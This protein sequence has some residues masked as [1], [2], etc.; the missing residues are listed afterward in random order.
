SNGVLITGRC[1]PW[2]KINQALIVAIAADRKARNVLPADVVMQIGSIGLQSGNLGADRYDLSQTTDLE[3]GVDTRHGVDADTDAAGSKD[4]DSLGG[5]FEVITAR[6][7]II[8]FVEAAAIRLRLGTEAG[9]G[10]RDRNYRI[11]NSGR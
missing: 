7:Q 11:R 8:E 10:I 4:G 3:L 9:S 1:R 6:Q 5:V 2:Y